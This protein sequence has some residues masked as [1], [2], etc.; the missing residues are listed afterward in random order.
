MGAR[1]ASVMVLALLALAAAAAPA[2]AAAA[3]SPQQLYPCS[4]CH[5]NLKVDAAVNVSEFH[6]IDLTKGAHRGLTCVNCH[7]PKS[8]MMKLQAGVD[9]A[10]LGVHNMSKVMEVAK[11]CAVCHQK[12]YEAYL[13][14]AHGNT[15]FTCPGGNA[16]E[17]IG[18]NGVNYYLHE[19]P[20]G[21]EYEAVPAKPCTACHDPHNPTYYALKPLPPPGHRP[22]PPDETPVLYGGVSVVVAGLA[23]IA[24][25][26]LVHKRL[27]SGEGGEG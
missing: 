5:A 27:R 17:I 15:T 11:M 2:A 19:C 14:H 13:R 12:E 22:P 7:D 6:G 23:L 3:Q 24:A 8:A 1:H 25:A 9:L 20:R 21:A 26:P 10:I 16:T 18:Y 4:T